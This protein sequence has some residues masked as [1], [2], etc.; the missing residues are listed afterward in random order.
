VFGAAQDL[1][2]ELLSGLD[3][4]ERLTAY[5]DGARTDINIPVVSAEAIAAVQGIVEE[6]LESHPD[7]KA[8]YIHGEDNLK[9]VAAANKGVAIVMP[10][11]KKEDLFRYVSQKGALCKKAFSM[12]E[13]QEKRYYVEAK[14]I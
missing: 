13:A 8:D 9:A 4:K 1:I 5:C 11:I 2:D 14:R 7:C 12:G 10:K 6:Y 3:G